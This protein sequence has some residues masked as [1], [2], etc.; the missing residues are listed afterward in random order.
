MTLILWK[1][2]VPTLTICNIM[3]KSPAL[4]NIFK[5]IKRSFAFN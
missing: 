3:V 4:V 1:I 2:N 5:Y